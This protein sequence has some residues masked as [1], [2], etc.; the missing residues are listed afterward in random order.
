MRYSDTGHIYFCS[1]LEVDEGMV[2]WR[3]F[4]GGQGGV[5]GVNDKG[6]F[7]AMADIILHSPK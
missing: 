4:M 5:I 6:S 2:V 3:G 7:R 1:L